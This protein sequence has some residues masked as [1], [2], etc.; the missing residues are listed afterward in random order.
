MTISLSVALTPSF[1]DACNESRSLLSLESVYCFITGIRNLKGNQKMLIFSRK[2]GDASIIADDIEVT[3]LGISGG[4]VKLG[5]VAP[6]DM[7]VHRA[8]V[9][10]KI[11]RKKFLESHDLLDSA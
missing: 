2:T 9:Y 11:E 4:T 1:C 10:C 6:D 8:E 3:V 5:I 7:Q